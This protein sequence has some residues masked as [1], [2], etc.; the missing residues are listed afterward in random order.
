MAIMSVDVCSSSTRST[1]ACMSR[2]MWYG[3]WP[4]VRARSMAAAI[5]GARPTRVV[6]VVVHGERGYMASGPLL[7]WRAVGREK[8]TG[9]GGL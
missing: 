8:G 3:V 7:V 4:C 9:D 5:V 2:A 1:G 6:V